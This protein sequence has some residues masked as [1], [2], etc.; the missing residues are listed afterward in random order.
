MV[1]ETVQTVQLI[2]KENDF[3]ASNKFVSIRKQFC[4]F[5]DYWYHFWIDEKNDFIGIY[6]HLNCPTPV[7]ASYTFT[8]NSITK[9]GNYTYKIHEGRG[10][11]NFG[12]RA[13]LFVNGI[14]KLDAEIHFRI[15]SKE[16]PNDE[17][18]QYA[19]LLNDER[20]KDFTI[21]VNH[22]R[23]E[24]HKNVVAVA[25]PVFSA[26]LK[27]NCEEFRNGEVFIK[28]FDYETVK[29]GVEF[30]YTHKIREN[31]KVEF[32]LDLY[33]FADKY[34]LVNTDL[35]SQFY[36]DVVLKMLPTK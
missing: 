1:F 14:L 33:K 15:P 3:D 23:I 11:S 12:K 26:M 22:R 25:S 29:A 32:L 18:S 28:D 21:H 24:V 31:S 8:I 7:T 20:F 4:L 16:V 36:E 5:E 35:D 2:V 6:L 10:W 9:T 30:M 13:D 17:M 19:A 27:P 34:D